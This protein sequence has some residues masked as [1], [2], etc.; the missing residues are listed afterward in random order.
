MVEGLGVG[1]KAVLVK[2]EKLAREGF[3][4][5]QGPR[6]PRRIMLPKTAGKIHTLRIAILQHEPL[7][8]A[9]GYMIEP[10]HV[11]KPAGHDAFF[12][13]K[14]LIELRMD[15]GRVA[16]LIVGSRRNIERVTQP[17]WIQS[18]S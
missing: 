2:V 9:W 15:A 3:L 7:A 12:T 13:G 1:S 10:Q 17:Y 6:R 18:T 11:L 5:D 14:G 4:E 16:R 8:L